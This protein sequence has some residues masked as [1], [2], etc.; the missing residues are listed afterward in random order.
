MPKPRVAVLGLGIMGGGM[1]NRLLSMGF[2]VS[3]YNRSPE[4][5]A[6]LGDAGAFVAATPREAAA[7]SEMVIAMVADDAASRD[8]WLGNDGALAGAVTG[9]LLLESS[10]LSVGWVKELNRAAAAK[11]CEFLDAPV[12]GTKPHAAKGELFFMVGGSSIGF[13]RAVEILSALGREVLHL[14]PTGSGALIKLINNFVCGVEAAAFA[15]AMVLV[16]AG[17]LDRE[18]CITVLGNSALASPLIKRMLIS[19]ESNDFTPNFP[20][21]LMTKDIGYAIKEA[22]TNGVQLETAVPA[23]EAF[24][25][26]VESGLGEQDFSAVVKAHAKK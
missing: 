4:K 12:T 21:K 8:I 5:A 17:G 6:R 13:S 18:K 19:M 7:R 9:S 16:S 3:V 14:G 15:E 22:E 23:L 24:R 1:A 25:R 11:G 2:S 20:L 10:T 26:A